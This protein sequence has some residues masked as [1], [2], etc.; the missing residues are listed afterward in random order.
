MRTRSINHH[1]GRETCWTFSGSL[2]AIIFL[3]VNAILVGDALAQTPL[4]LWAKAA[5]GVNVDS[6]R[7]IAL[8]GSGNSYVTGYFDSTNVTFGTTTLA[9]SASDG[10]DEIFVAKYDRDG[11]VLWARSAGG[12]NYDKGAGIAVDGG[13]NCYVTGS[14]QGP[15]SFSGTILTNAAGM[16][17]AKYDS[18]GNVVWVARAVGLE[19]ASVSGG[20]GV[21]L[22]A[23]ANCY[24]TGNSFGQYIAFA[25]ATNSITLTNNDNG[26]AAFVAKYDSSGN[27]VWAA[28]AVTVTSRSVAADA[29]GNSYVAGNFGYFATFGTITL[30]NVNT[31]GFPDAFVAK[32]DSSGDV[33]WA[34]S[35]GGPEADYGMAIASDGSGCHVT[36]SY[37]APCTFG[38]VTLTNGGIFIAKYDSSGNMFWAKSAG[39]GS[40]SSSGIAVD[41]AANCYVTGNYSGPST[42]G[43]ITLT[44]TGLFVA[45]Y[46]SSGNVPWA[47]TAVGSTRGNAIAADSV[48][49]CY[50]AGGL[51]YSGTFDNIT[52]TDSGNNPNADILVTKIGRPWVKILRNAS[53][54]TFAWTTNVT[55]FA[56]ESA[57]NLPAGANW[58]A[59]TNTPV[60]VGD[61]FTVTNSISGT[62][63][64]YRLRK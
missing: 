60:R 28:L 44:N 58:T 3:T 59:V 62:N 52:L 17:H 4:F 42:F 26:S 19:Y 21:S 30:T 22:D 36:G 39:S 14:F 54:L 6:G 63:K 48:G 38:G 47:K 13:G 25:G 41:G 64:F 37:S 7:A 27:V 56:L 50:V 23:S 2:S 8:D 33:L 46:D 18:A 55:G 5:G 10:S 34:K 57:T 16:F 35:A 9:N 49:N 24:V 53:Q 1:F 51:Y 31:S 61:Q 15:A 12:T 11:N 20:T 43:G 32:Y 40:D 29:V 45:K